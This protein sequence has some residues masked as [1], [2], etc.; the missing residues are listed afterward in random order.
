[1]KYVC[2]IIGG[3]ASAVCWIRALDRYGECQAVFANTN[4][5]DP[6]LYRFLDDMEKHTG[7]P[8]VRLNNGDDIWATFRKHSA[9]T[10]GS[11]CVA[12]YRLKYMQLRGW[13][14]A[15]CEPAY[16]TVLIGMGP[17]EEDRQIRVAKRVAPYN[18]DFPLCW[19]PK[20]WTCDVEDF[21][22]R[23]GLKLPALYAKGYPHNNC[24][25]A[26]IMAGIAQWTGVLKD[27][28]ERFAH[29]EAEEQKMLQLIEERERVPW[30]I[31]KD[32]RG[33]EHKTYSLKQLREDIE[34]GRRMPDD[35]WRAK[36]CSCMFTWPEE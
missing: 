12:S 7:L 35:K 29:A 10:N 6:D 19:E 13:M 22:K 33:G 32:R 2:H 17:D 36:S 34:A 4:S 1:M 14:D 26:C 31:L 25:G 24:G 11:G 5:E 21:L 15:N 16:T 27:Y 20:L 28:P 3:A 23:R 30:T 18:V 9:F 8:I